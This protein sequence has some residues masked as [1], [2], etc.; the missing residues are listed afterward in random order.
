MKHLRDLRMV[1]GKPM[2]FCAL[3]ATRCD[4][5]LVTMDSL[6]KE[7]FPTENLVGYAAGV[8]VFLLSFYVLSTIL[9]CCPA[10]DGLLIPGTS[11]YCFLEKEPF[12]LT[13]TLNRL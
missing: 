2:I 13:F 3:F 10:M 8:S 5:S 7:I 6:R 4:S 1:E 12:T 11:V 9:L